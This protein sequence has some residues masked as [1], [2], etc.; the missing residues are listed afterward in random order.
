MSST[1]NSTKLKIRKNTVIKNCAPFTNSISE[2]NNVQR[3]N[4]N[5]IVMP[6]YDLI[7]YSNNYSK[8][9]ECLW[10]YYRVEPF[11]ESNGAILN[12]PAKNNNSAS[13]ISASKIAGLIGSDGRK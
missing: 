9:F 7:E 8:T 6:M 1:S 4:A 2:I 11:L 10:Q 5:D 13:V 12:F 3:D